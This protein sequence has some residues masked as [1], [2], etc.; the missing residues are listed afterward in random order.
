MR[1]SS[2]WFWFK[3]YKLWIIIQIWRLVPH[4]Q[5]IQDK[6]CAT[7]NMGTQTAKINYEISHFFNKLNGLITV[8]WGLAVFPNF[9][10]FAESQWSRKG[11]GV[12]SRRISNIWTDE[13]C[14][15]CHFN[16]FLFCHSQSALREASITFIHFH[17]STVLFCSNFFVLFEMSVRT[18]KNNDNWIKSKRIAH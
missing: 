12:Q 2:E 1:S 16:L 8:L 9:R 4:L 3:V 18:N 15:H 7:Y 5:Q 10:I 11:G 13:K 14:G 6:I 17:I